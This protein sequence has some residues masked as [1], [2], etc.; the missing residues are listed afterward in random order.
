MKF[1][2][3]T[4][5][6]LI[7]CGGFLASESV[8]AACTGSSPTWIAADCSHTE[9][10]ACITAAANG[11]TVI[12]PAG[13]CIW[14]SS[15]NISK[16]I[17][18]QGAGIGNTVINRAGTAIKLIETSARITG[19]TFNL[20]D[21]ANISMDIAGGVG[22]RIDHNK[23]VNTTTGV[24]RYSILISSTN[25]QSTP[26]GLVD[27]NDFVEGRIDTSFSST[28][29]EARALWA[30]DHLF[31]STDPTGLHT[32]YIEDNTFYKS[33][34][35]NVVDSGF[36]GAYVARYNKVTGLTQFQ[37]HSL[38]EAITR[39]SRGWEIYGNSFTGATPTWASI[40]IRGG[41]G[42]VFNNSI[43]NYTYGVIFDNVRSFTNIPTA[44]LCDGSSPWDGN[45]DTNGWPCRDQIGRGKDLSL[46]TEENPYPDQESRPAYVWSNIKSGSN[47]PVYVH[48]NCGDWIQADRDYFEYKA[49]FNGTAGVGCGTMANR[50]AT[51]TAGVGYWATNQSC[52]DLTSTTGTSPETPIAGT[53]FKC[54]SADH[55]EAY[56]TP[57]TY[58]HPLR[59]EDIEIDSMPPAAPTG[60]SII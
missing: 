26:Y 7:F 35:S 13:E 43:A 32:V 9:V 51:C 31:G 23:F 58:P 45:I 57:Y 5:Y 11:D 49:A 12:V 3:F 54:T 56:Y 6:T 55:W 39:G 47:I 27:N 36:S 28:I 4:I 38:Q 21:S 59:A 25:V 33:F 29:P 16:N 42:F 24:S 30:E 17:T 46:W 18:L 2:K 34:V 41:T 10:A 48:N 60:L 40:F 52:T 53:L 20:T 19:F 1:L 37:V 50:P 44:G 8:Q 22:W 15:L 14:T